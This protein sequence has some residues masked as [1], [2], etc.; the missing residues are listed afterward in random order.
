VGIRMIM[1]M[2]VMGM[3][4]ADSDVLSFIR[5]PSSRDVPLTYILEDGSHHPVPCPDD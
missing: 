5:D 2:M 4:V 1:M 3:V